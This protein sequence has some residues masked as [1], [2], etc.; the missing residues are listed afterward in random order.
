MQTSHILAKK[1][2]T[3]DGWVKKTK[4]FLNQFLP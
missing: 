3:S 4:A 2:V 1:D